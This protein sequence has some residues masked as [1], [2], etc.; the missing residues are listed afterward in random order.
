VAIH[1]AGT[2]AELTLL[3]RRG[4]GAR[5]DLAGAT[6]VLLEQLDLGDPEFGPTR[7]AF[8]DSSARG[9]AGSEAMRAFVWQLCRER[10]AECWSRTVELVSEHRQAIETLADRLLY[11]P[12][13][14]FGVESVAAAMARPAEREAEAVA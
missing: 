5:S 12:Q 1:L 2:C 10:F 8:E 6:E 14:T 11:D 3:G 4:S 13:V 7:Q 9:S